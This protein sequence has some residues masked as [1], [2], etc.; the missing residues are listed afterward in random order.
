MY[1]VNC[2]IVYMYV[3]SLHNMALFS[4]CMLS[5]IYNGH[6][7]ISSCLFAYR[8]QS[9]L[10]QYVSSVLLASVFY[11]GLIVIPLVLVTLKCRSNPGIW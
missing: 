8:I 9:S 7:L 10:Q 11:T 4:T 3:C 2:I 6:K 1:I 5:R